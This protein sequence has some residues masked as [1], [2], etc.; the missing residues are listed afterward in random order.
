MQ[1]IAESIEINKSRASWKRFYGGFS[2]GSFWDVSEPIQ[3]ATKKKIVKTQ[4]VQIFRLNNACFK[5]QV[6]RKV[7]LE[8]N[9]INLVN[10][11]L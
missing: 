3:L 7:Y 10:I 8:E 11:S 9:E 1:I 5:W 2:F 4:I 6:E